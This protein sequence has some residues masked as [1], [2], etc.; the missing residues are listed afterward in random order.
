MERTNSWLR[1]TAALFAALVLAFGLV[2]CSFAPASADEQGSEDAGDIASQQTSTEEEAGDA[3]VAA[4]QV[5]DSPGDVDADAEA[6]GTEAADAVVA[7]AIAADSAT[8]EG[9]PA[10]RG[11]GGIEDAWKEHGAAALLLY[12]WVGEY[13]GSSSSVTVRR[14][15]ELQFDM[16]EGENVYG[17]AVVSPSDKAL[18]GYG[19]NGSYDFSGTFDPENFSIHIQGYRWVSYPVGQD[20]DNFRFLEF[21]GTVDFSTGTI[22]GHTERGIWT[23]SAY[24]NSDFAYDSGFKLGVDNNSYCHTSS[25]SYENAGFVGVED[26]SVSKATYEKL[27]ALCQ[28][29]AERS[30]LKE[31]QQGAW[32]GS[33]YGVASTIGETF[34]GR[35]SL[36]DINGAGAQSYFDLPLPYKDQAFKDAIDFYQLSHYLSAGFPDDAVIGTTYQYGFFDSLVNTVF[37]IDAVEGDSLS[38]FLKKIVMNPTDDDV[39]MLTYSTRDEG[40]AI[41][42]TGCEYNSAKHRYEVKIYDENSVDPARQGDARGA[43]STLRISDDYSGFQFVNDDGDVKFDDSDTV[44]M[45]VIDLEALPS[46]TNGAAGKSVSARMA[47]ASDGVT[48]EVSLAAPFRIENAD[49]AYIAYDGTELSGDLEIRDMTVNAVGDTP[50]LSIVTASSGTYTVEASAGKT[51]VSLRDA[52]DR[53]YSVVGEGMDT[54]IFD[55]GEG[56]DLSGAGYSFTAFASTSKA[57]SDTESGLLSVSGMASGKVGIANDG[58]GVTVDG[59]VS[60]LVVGSYEEGDAFQR[61]VGDLAEPLDVTHEYVAAGTAQEPTDPGEGGP[62]DPGESTGS[63]ELGDAGTDTDANA[64]AGTDTGTD[65]EGQGDKGGLVEGDGSNDDSATEDGADQELKP[66][67]AKAGDSLLPATLIIGALSISLIA[68]AV[69]AFFL[70]RGSHRR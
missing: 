46:Y 70:R 30:Y 27:A 19:V 37:G 60:D 7:N 16:V 44:M 39:R 2:P 67:L 58:E 36:D 51:D 50:I 62:T 14:N 29:K 45:Q 1:K 68:I 35:L 43:F 56:I 47:D 3:D 40:H 59:A 34:L 24:R 31:L 8:A 5:A 57:V 21:D 54:V 38:V 25:S 61:E 63:D 13:D 65:T 12:T 15:Y 23:M 41:L 32:G 48:I 22:T 53:F 20:V 52:Q 6:A 26:Y 55:W 42:I 17:T 66:L 11:A 69:S 49:G 18:E 9:Q 33:C 4:D 64:D 10:S 28:D